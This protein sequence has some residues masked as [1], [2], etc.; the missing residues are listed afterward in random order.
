MNFSKSLI[1]ALNFAERIGAFLLLPFLISSLTKTEYAIW[2][3]FIII[4]PLVA[5]V[6]SMG[7]GRG[8]LNYFSNKDE[9]KTSEYY[10][11]CVILF[12]SFATVLILFAINQ[13]YSHQISAFLFG[14]QELHYLSQLLI[15]TIFIEALFEI[16]TSLIRSKQMFDQLSI[17]IGYRLFIKY[18]V[19]IGIFYFSNLSFEQGISTYIALLFLINVPYLFVFFSRLVGMS[20]NESSI[21]LFKKLLTYSFPLMISG[22]IFPFLLISGRQVLLT[23]SGPEVLADFSL[24]YS[25]LGIPVMIAQTTNYIFFTE[26]ALMFNSNKISNFKSFFKNYLVINVFIFVTIS[27]CIVFLYQDILFILGAPNYSIDLLSVMAL[28][29]FFVLFFIYFSYYQ[30]AQLSL[31]SETHKI[32]VINIISS[33]ASLLALQ[34]FNS[35][36][37][38]SLSVTL[39]IYFAL[40]FILLAF[41]LRRE[42]MFIAPNNNIYKVLILVMIQVIL[43][44]ILIQMGASEIIRIIICIG[45]FLSLC[46]LD[47]ATKRSILIDFYKILTR[48]V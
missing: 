48:K 4:P 42:S 3:Q 20:F 33:I 32:L 44:N 45:I 43:T 29:L 14:N 46:L 47:Y 30:V 11:I 25:L 17:F 7:L 13:F 16:T 15:A 35:F 31:H 21:K 28:T 40:S 23:R 22:F 24:A 26:M 34:L 27:V 41:L 5:T 36:G 37:I 2:T 9:K 8:M 10:V 39:I 6:I 38:L 18:V 12:I 1:V 19:V